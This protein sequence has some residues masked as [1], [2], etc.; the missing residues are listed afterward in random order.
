MTAG[1][2]TFE[3]FGALAR[4]FTHQRYSKTEVAMQMTTDV[5]IAAYI[6]DRVDNELLFGEDE[7]AV[8]SGRKSGVALKLGRTTLRV[9]TVMEFSQLTELGTKTSSASM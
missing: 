8:G 1:L 6:I 3:A 5:M 4:F 7:V 9:G 2:L